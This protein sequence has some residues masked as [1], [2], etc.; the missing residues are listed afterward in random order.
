MS[1]D[2]L[3][4]EGFAIFKNGS[5]KRLSPTHYVVKSQESRGWHLIELKEGK[6]ICDCQAD[7]TTCP[8]LYAAQFHRYTSKEKPEEL[9]EA[10]LKCRYCNSIDI[11]GC[12]FR[13]GARG[14]SRRFVCHD[15]LRKFSIPYTNTSAESKPQELAWLLNQVGQLTS[16]LTDLL[17]EINAKLETLIATPS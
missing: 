14:I 11:A 4:E 1:E 3:R 7:G 17:Q 16:K 5:L 2:N 6:W 9:D 15:C 8:H 13:Y 10:H 12:G